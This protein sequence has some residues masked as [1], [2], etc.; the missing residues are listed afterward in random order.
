MQSIL[1]CPDIQSTDICVF[2]DGPR[3]EH[4]APLVAETEA[5]LRQLLGSSATFFV[6]NENSGCRKSIVSGVSYL[7]ANAGRVIVIE[8]D[9]VVSPAFLWFMN[10]A[11]EK[12]ASYP[13]VMH[14]CGYMY[15]VRSF[16]NL[17]HGLFFPFMMP[18]G[19]A[20]WEQSWRLY[21]PSAAGAH[22]LVTDNAL[23]YDFD[24]QD[25]RDYSGML[26]RQLAGDLDAWDIL[27][28]WS[29]FKRN[30]LSYF[31]PRSLVKNIGFDGSGTHGFLSA[32][33]GIGRQ[34]LAPAGSRY[35]APTV[36]VATG[37]HH[38]AMWRAS[39]KLGKHSLVFRAKRARNLL[40]RIG[41]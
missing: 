12:F 22:Q 27:W 18:W 11:L 35:E 2:I 25:A 13:E 32:R 31:P 21:D 7:C 15:P 37:A 1:A 17:Q 41:I 10:D 34:K 5:S 39:A 24:F 28:Y 36:Q 3:D 30:G 19:W 38:D 33:L 29:I 6:S 20:T 26:M 23:R 4:D 14:V 16:Q 9:L 8:D 40:R